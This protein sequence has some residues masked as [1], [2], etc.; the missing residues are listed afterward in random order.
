LRVAHVVAPLGER[1]PAEEL[2][3]DLPAAA[4][5]EFAEALALGAENAAN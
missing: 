2:L 3:F 4:A 5:L 1:L